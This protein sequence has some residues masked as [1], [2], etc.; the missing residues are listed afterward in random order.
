[1]ATNNRERFTRGAAWVGL[2]AGMLLVAIEV[3]RVVKGARWE[4]LFWCFIGACAIAFCLY[5]LLHGGARPPRGGAG[6]GG[7][8]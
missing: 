2:A 3:V 6:R 4:S 1:M 8:G 5:E 7:L